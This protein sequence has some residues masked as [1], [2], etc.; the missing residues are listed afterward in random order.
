[1]S[2]KAVVVPFNC[3]TRWQTG[4]K[5]NQRQRHSHTLRKCKA[6]SLCERRYQEAQNQYENALALARKI[7]DRRVEVN[8]L[9][10]LANLCD[11][12]R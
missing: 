5:Q 2:E 4:F 10:N 3:A 8:I 7:G 9:T 1:M 12:Q 6:K 11:P